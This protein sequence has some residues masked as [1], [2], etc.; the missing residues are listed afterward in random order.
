MNTSIPRKPRF[1]FE[2]GVPAENERFGRPPS[3]WRRRWF[4]II[5]A[6]DTPA[7][8]RF[9]VVL[10]AVILL[11][12]LV[13]MLDSVQGIGRENRTTFIVLEWCFTLL[14]TAEYVMRLLCVQ[15]PLR[16]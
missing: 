16:Y 5:F 15:R 14:F 9:D 6:S 2:S 1:L 13:V 11:S 3:G 10:L 8:R 4:D 12:V 7:G